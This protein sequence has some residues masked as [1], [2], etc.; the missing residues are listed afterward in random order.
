MRSGTSSHAT[1][2]P[3][4]NNSPR[5]SESTETPTPPNRTSHMSM[6]ALR[7][8]TNIKKHPADSSRCD[9]D[10]QLPFQHGTPI[11]K[12]DLRR[13]SR[14]PRNILTEKDKILILNEPL[15][16]ET[17]QQFI[18]HESLHAHQNYMD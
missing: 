15:E 5:D 13:N 3:K 11:Y 18:P 6:R 7:D 14:R 1:G 10:T 2:R 12:Q 16:K 9:V 8:N 4:P 17:N